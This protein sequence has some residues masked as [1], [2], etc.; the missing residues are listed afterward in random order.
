MPPTPTLFAFGSNGSGQLGIG[1]AEDV[2][3]PTRCLFEDS[4]SSSSKQP[5]SH[6]SNQTARVS[7]IVA[8]G[9]HTLVLLDD[10]RV[11]AAGCNEDG[12]CGSL[13][14]RDSIT[15]ADASSS[16]NYTFKR[17]FVRD[18]E[19]G[20]EYG[21]FKSVSAM[22]EATVLVTSDER[23]GG[24]VVFVLGSGGKG[25]LGLGMGK[26]KTQAAAGAGRM[27]S[28]PP[29]GVSVVSVSSGMGHTVV[30]CSDGS[31]YGWGA[32]RKG[33]LGGELVG[34]KIVWEPRPVT[35]V[36]FRVTDAVC[37]REFTV[38]CGDREKG[39]F[40]V[41]GSL[42]DKWGVVS[43]V[44]SVDAVKG[45]SGV[46]ASWHGVYIHQKDLS[47]RAWGRNDRGQVPPT[48]ELMGMREVAVG[49]EH[50]LA[51]LGDGS[52]VAF[53]WGEHGNC[54]PDTDARGDV[55][56]TCS[57]IPRPEGDFE[58]VGVGAGCATS[59]IIAS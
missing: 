11:Y 5:E 35:E 40:V 2:S 57:R 32:A 30:V 26:T 8:G 13:V 18:S 27:P 41:L 3:V 58:V 39:E 47:V 59:W 38:L 34:E 15:D 14:P 16:S 51:L 53:G 6:S 56:G 17:V 19:S 21:G 12:R 54:G 24:D 25:E 37:G 50:G 7:R 48:G 33:Q 42:G 10:G 22:W 44:P 43:G 36:G 4:L 55:K 31:V 45:Y 20:I 46:D 28:F 23:G 9:N 52:V 29:P 1:H 49:S